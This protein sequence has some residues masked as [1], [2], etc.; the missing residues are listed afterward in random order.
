MVG[1]LDASSGTGHVVYGAKQPVA[2]SNLYALGRGRGR[3]QVLQWYWRGNMATK[4]A[5]RVETTSVFS[6]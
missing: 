3:S 6:I 2:T 5:M 1:L 4:L